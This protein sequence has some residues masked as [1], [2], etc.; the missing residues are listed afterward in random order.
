MNTRTEAR[1]VLTGRASKG[2]AKRLRHHGF[3][4]VAEPES[5]LVTTDNHLVRYEEARAE[6]WGTHLAEATT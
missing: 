1:A 4:V 5:F 2:I 6:E 3:H